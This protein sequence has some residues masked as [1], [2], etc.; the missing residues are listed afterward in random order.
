MQSAPQLGKERTVNMAIRIHALAGAIL[1]AI[2]LG[3]G[4][5]SAF[6]PV[7]GFNQFGQMRFAVWPIVDFDTN[8]NGVIEVGEGLPFRLESGPRGFTPEEI[9]LVKEGFQVWEN[10]STS[11]V[12]FRFQGEFQDSIVP[13]ITAPDYV[14]TV[15]MQVTDVGGQNPQT[16]GSNFLPDLVEAIIPEVDSLLGVTLIAY[17]IADVPIQNGQSTTIVP[18]GNILDCDIIISAAAHREVGLTSLGALDL[19]AT[20]VHTVG[21]ALGLGP[22]P[23][24]NLEP[25]DTETGV[26]LPTETA[27][28]QL[29]GPDGIPQLVGATPSMFPVAFLT[30]DSSGE[31]IFGWRDLAP[32]DIS[33]VSFLYPLKDGQENF[34][35][36]S[37]EARTRTRRGTGIPSAPISGAHIVAWADVANSGGAVRIPL[38]STM[39]GLYV[40]YTNRNLVGKF[41]LV[42]L[43]KQ[44]EIPSTA[45]QFFT[46]SYT[47]T[48]S[49]LDGSGLERQAPPGLGPAAFD[50][51]QGTPPLSFT[52]N[53]RGDAEFSTNYVS[54]VFNENGNLYGIENYAAGT[55]IVWDFKKNQ[56]VSAKSGKII[57]TMLPLNRPMFGD[58]NDVCPLNVLDGIG[59]SGA[60]E[61]GTTIDTETITSA[62]L[63]KMNRSLRSF[64]DHVLLQSAIGTALVDTWYRLAPVL[65]RFLARNAPAF[66]LARGLI[67]H[68]YALCL[69]IAGMLVASGGVL[70]RIRRRVMQ[71]SHAGG[72]GFPAVWMLIVGLLLAGGTAQAQ[73]LPRSTADMVAGAT[74]VLHGKVVEARG[75]RVPGAFLIY[76]DVTLEL[77]GT[78]KGD[79][80]TDA[81]NDDMQ[82]QRVT[83]SV[84]GGQADGIGLVA[85]GIPSF[86]EG[87]EVIL[88]MREYPGR[89]L[90]IFGGVQ[91]KQLVRVNTETQEKVVYADNPAGITALKTDWKVMNKAA[92]TEA[93]EKAGAA[94]DFSEGGI[95][96][97]VYMEYLRELAAAR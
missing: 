85:S 14:P 86:A 38:F 30:E 97:D 45:G 55:P 29:T 13:G 28:L 88:Y 20:I 23:L 19:K 84:I 63:G 81:A 66:S 64:R 32:D 61:G 58:P 76:T 9:K 37:Q 47:L 82:S 93:P 78:A 87:E 54:E 17:A 52:V 24:N 70:Y 44:L 53:V 27:A 77:I 57:P 22:T 92:V 42:G 6:F 95:P 26:G 3:A 40:R 21:T 35:T 41:H 73:L 48:M 43:W 96:V 49:P 36:V 75:R 11:F 56:P 74:H 34:F 15:F 12:R 8:N 7:G 89:G 39:S 62:V 25:F 46:T 16:G 18:S 4:D 10:V 68:L 1:A 2:V 65:A 94:P 90:V 69:V 33:G 72:T 67:T 80:K 5:A 83:F 51:M 59:T 91:G 50:S 60:G 71:E 79:V 31:R